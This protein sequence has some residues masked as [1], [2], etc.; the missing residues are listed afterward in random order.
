[1]LRQGWLSTLNVAH[2]R[3]MSAGWAEPARNA[4]LDGPPLRV[5]RTH[6]AT[7]FRLSLDI[8]D[9][10]HTV[11]VGPTGAGKSVLLAMLVAQFRRYTGSHVFAFEMGRSLRATILGLGGEYHDLGLSGDTASQTLARVVAPADPSPS[12][13]RVEGRP[14]WYDGVIRTE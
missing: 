8:G 4:H 1:M 6:G 2:L 7:P 14:A 10:G 13:C 9:V 5:G 12:A 11:V 3:L